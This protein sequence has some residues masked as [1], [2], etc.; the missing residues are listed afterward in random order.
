MPSLTPP[1]TTSRVSPFTKAN[2]T[3]TGPSRLGTTHAFKTSMSGGENV[4]FA[5][6]EVLKGKHETLL[7]EHGTSIS[8]IELLEKKLKEALL[9][10]QK[11]DYW[12]K[13]YLELHKKL[14]TVVNNI[15][16]LMYSEVAGENPGTA[17]LVVIVL[18]DDD[19][20]DG[21]ESSGGDSDSE[22]QENLSFYL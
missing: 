16:D 20:G 3:L 13:K 2:G 22:N 19:E 1:A 8:T 9:V 5:E 6:H 10:E 21:S 7:R 15:K 18:S 11:G 4:S 17:A 14:E 12:E